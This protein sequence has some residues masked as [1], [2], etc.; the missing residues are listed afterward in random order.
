M[1]THVYRYEAAHILT[2]LTFDA[3]PFPAAQF[4]TRIGQAGSFSLPSPL[5]VASAQLGRRLQ[6]VAAGA[7]ALYVYRDAALWWGGVAWTVTPAGDDQGNA[8]WTVQGADWISYLAR[9]DFQTDYTSSAG[10]PLDQVR[11]LLANMQADPYADLGIVADTTESGLSSPATAYLASGN[12]SY[13]TAIDD[14]A[15]QAPGFDYAASTSVDPGTGRRTRRLRLGYPQIGS[16]VVHRFT[17]PG[18]ILTYSLPADATTG[19]T[20]WRAFGATSNSN[21]AS[22]SQPTVSALYTA[23]AQLAAGWPRLDAG[24]TYSTV[25]DI[26]TLDAYAQADLAAG[27]TPVV[28]PQLTVELDRTDIT[29]DSLG[30]MAVINITD[31]N[32]PDGLTQTSRIVGIQVNTGDRANPEVATIVFN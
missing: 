18:N 17:R 16:N 9:V 6:Q 5:G 15:T 29:P 10:D 23:A 11:A 28:I 7:C 26:P 21:Q 3:L 8:T 14:L 32:F 31:P 27:A 2:D 24:N 4:D 25:S 13:G 19:G 1:S 22:T 30:D 20:E 12:S